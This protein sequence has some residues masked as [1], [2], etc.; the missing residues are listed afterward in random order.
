MGSRLRACVLAEQP[1]HQDAEVSAANERPTAHRPFQLKT[2]TL[3]HFLLADVALVGDGLDPVSGG[4]FQQV[5][6]DELLRGDTDS[7]PAILRYQG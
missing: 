7:L 2:Q 3:Q 1:I 6:D 4:V 5:I